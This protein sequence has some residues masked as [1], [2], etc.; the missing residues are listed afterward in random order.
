MINTV[1][2]DDKNKC[3]KITLIHG[4]RRRFDSFRDDLNMIPCYLSGYFL[5][6]WIN[7][8]LQESL[9]SIVTLV[10]FLFYQGKK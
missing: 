9:G 5:A 8:I 7:S 10:A 4:L 1:V 3:E 6:Y 2:Q